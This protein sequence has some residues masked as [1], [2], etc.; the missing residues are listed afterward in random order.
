MFCNGAGWHQTG[1]AL[2]LPDHIRRPRH[3]LA[4]PS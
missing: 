4:V 2:Q 3:H 1:W